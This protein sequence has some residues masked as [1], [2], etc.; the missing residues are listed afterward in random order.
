MLS[1]NRHLWLAVA[2]VLTVA[3]VSVLAAD[4]A[5]ATEIATDPTSIGDVSSGP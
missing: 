1:D 3:I 5:A 2:T 4:G